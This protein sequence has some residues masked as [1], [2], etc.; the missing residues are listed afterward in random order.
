MRKRAR[1]DHNQAEVVFALRT[2]GAFVQSLATVGDGCPDLLVGFQGETYL[3]EIKD[4]RKPPSAR[5]LTEDEGRWH[6]R[7][8]GGACAVVKSQIEALEMIGAM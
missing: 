2:A 5:K 6:E 3:M 4:G 8:K 7:W 1:V